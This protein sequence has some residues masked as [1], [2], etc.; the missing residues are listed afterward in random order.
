[1]KKVLSIALAA[2]IVALPLPASQLLAAGASPVPASV[3]AEIFA[4][5]PNFSLLLADPF[6]IDDLSYEK[7][8]SFLDLSKV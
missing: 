8:V 4:G 2:A 5:D 3:E 6:L 1:M 7:P